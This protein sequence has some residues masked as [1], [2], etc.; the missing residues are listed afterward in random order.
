MFI[1]VYHEVLYRPLFN[2]LIFLYHILGQDLGIAILVLTVL[3]KLLLFYPS[4]QQLKAQ[5]N[6]QATQPKLKE[7]KER[8]KDNKEEYN[9]AVLRFYKE[10]KVNPASSCLPVLIQFPILIALYQVFIA[11]VASDPATGLLQ[12]KQ[13]QFLYFPLRE[14]YDSIPL[15]TTFLGIVDLAKNKN[16]LLA[17][18]TGLATFWQSSMLTRTQPPKSVGEAGKDESIAASVNKNLTYTLPLITVFFSYTLPAGLPLYWLVSTLFQI[19]QQY[20]FLRRHAPS[21]TPSS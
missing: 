14:I 17:L 8:Y 21:P 9:R 16:V 2:A 10:N 1:T 11:G 3:I 13:L 20:Y 5:R 12:A 18:L 4:L 19:G 15:H 6:L 7:L